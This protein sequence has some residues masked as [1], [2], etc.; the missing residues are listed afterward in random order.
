MAN[1][2]LSRNNSATVHLESEVRIGK[3]MFQ[4]VRNSSNK[5]HKYNESFLKRNRSKLDEEVVAARKDSSV[6][7]A[8]DTRWATIV[9]A[10]ATLNPL[11][12][13]AEIAACNWTKSAWECRR[14]L[15]SVQPTNRQELSFFQSLPASRFL[16]VLSLQ[17]MILFFLKLLL[18][19]R[20]VFGAFW[21]LPNGTSMTAALAQSSAQFVK[22]P[23]L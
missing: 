18:N 23:P 22:N 11:A 6:K 21:R 3:R 4:C 9:V 17:L 1:L 19:E 20:L 5:H 8:I 15:S 14:Q 12:S 10:T 13:W 7:S 2:F 16:V